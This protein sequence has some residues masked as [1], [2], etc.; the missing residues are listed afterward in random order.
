[1]ASTFNTYSDLLVDGGRLAETVW[2]EHTAAQA[3]LATTRQDPEAIV[4]V[5]IDH[6]RHVGHAPGGLA[7]LAQPV[8]A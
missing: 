1:M 6:R 7:W 2:P 5:A 8:S 3:V 4:L